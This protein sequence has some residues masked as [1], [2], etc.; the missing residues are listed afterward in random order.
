MALLV[1]LLLL[2][3]DPLSTTAESSGWKQ[4]GRYE[5]VERL[6]AAFPKRFPGKVKCEKFGTTP[7]GR[8]MLALVAS[9][10]AR[11]C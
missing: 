2:A 4:T 6:C 5:E 1:S 9:G 10:S 11:S 8:P 7:E 3:A